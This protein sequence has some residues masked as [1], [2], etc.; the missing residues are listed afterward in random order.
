MVTLLT[1]FS[2]GVVAVAL[3]GCT[4]LL[5]EWK[6]EALVLPALRAGL[7]HAWAYHVAY[8]VALVGAAGA[9]VR[10]PTV[11]DR[12]P[13]LH[14]WAGPGTCRPA[15]ARGDRSTTLSRA[16]AKTAVV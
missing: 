3:G 14:C 16:S 4:E 8:S 5:R 15:A 7:L 9:A 11:P 6:N 2:T 12:R 10:V 1:G 13:G